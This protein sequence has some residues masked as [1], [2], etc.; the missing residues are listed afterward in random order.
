MFDFGKI[1]VYDG[2]TGNGVV[3]LENGEQYK[4]DISKWSDT[5]NLPEI[6]QVVLIENDKVKVISEEEKKSLKKKLL[7]DERKNKEIEERNKEIKEKNRQKNKAEIEKLEVNILKAFE[8]M[9]KS[10]I[11]YLEK[12]YRLEGFETTFKNSEDDINYMLTMQKTMYDTT[13]EVMFFNSQLYF[14][15]NN[16]KNQIDLVTIK[17]KILA[18]VDDIINNK[19]NSIQPEYFN[20]STTE[21]DTNKPSNQNTTTSIEN[22]SDKKTEEPDVKGIASLILGIFG[23]FFL[24]IVLGPVSLILGYTAPKPKSTFAIAGMIIGGLLTAYTVIVI[25]GG[26][27]VFSSM[28]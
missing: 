7:E 4:F 28:R 24:P 8:K 25:I 16:E 15:K 12:Y 23:I 17:K 5:D 11:P 14:R 27:A 19:K 3:V 1:F 22:T 18:S 26:V 6:G 10:I 21:I 2:T 9:D 13:Y 20:T